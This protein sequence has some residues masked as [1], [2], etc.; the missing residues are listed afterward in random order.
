MSHTLWACTF[1]NTYFG[2]AHMMAYTLSMLKVYVCAVAQTCSAIWYSVTRNKEGSLW[3]VKV[4]NS[5]TRANSAAHDCSGSR[6]RLLVDIFGV[7]LQFVFISCIWKLWFT[8]N[9]LMVAVVF[10]SDGFFSD[11][12]SSKRAMI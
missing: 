10:I 8:L 4:S 11:V 1:S 12:W 6:P 3:H 2:L 7:T 9:Y 5:T